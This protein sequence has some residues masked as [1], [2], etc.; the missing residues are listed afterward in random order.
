MKKLLITGLLSAV[1]LSGCATKMKVGVGDLDKNAMQEFTQISQSVSQVVELKLDK[2]RVKDE[3]TEKTP[4][5]EELKSFIYSITV[6]QVGHAITGGTPV[7]SQLTAY[8][9][10]YAIKEG[11]YAMYNKDKNSYVIIPVFDS[12]IKTDD[13]RFSI[14]IRANAGKDRD[15][16]IKIMEINKNPLNKNGIIHYEENAKNKVIIHAFELKSPS[17][18][19]SVKYGVHPFINGLVDVVIDG[20]LAGR[21]YVYGNAI[22]ALIIKDI[23]VHQNLLITIFKYH[24][25]RDYNKGLLPYE[26]RKYCKVPQVAK[27]ENKE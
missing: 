9:M 13:C 26:F 17:Y 20:K 18:N 4:F 7:A 14:E 2:K 12:D 8:A 24:T 6:G 27:S 3:T 22:R 19:Q 21:Y 23:N 5:W 10:D 11:L 16:F 1:V 25:D 15:E